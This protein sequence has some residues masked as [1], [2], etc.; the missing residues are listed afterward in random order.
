MKIFKLKL[1][2]REKGAVC[3]VTQNINDWHDLGDE[4]P[5]E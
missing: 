4:E 2:Y 5:L 1:K 3:I